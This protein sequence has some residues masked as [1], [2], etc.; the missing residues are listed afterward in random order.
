[1]PAAEDDWYSAVSGT[2][3]HQGD[4]VPEFKVPVVSSVQTEPDGALTAESGVD[5]CD[6]I[7]LTQT[8]DLFQRRGQDVLL[9][10]VVSWASVA[11]SE[12][13]AGNTLVAS[14]AFRGKLIEGSVP[15]LS[16]LH[17]RLL[18]PT[19]PWSAANFE[20]VHSAPGLPRRLPRRPGRRSPPAIVS[21]VPGAFCP[22]V[23]ALLHACWPPPRCHRFRRRGAEIVRQVRERV[24]ND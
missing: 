1:M 3:V 18:P 13:R 19:M 24:E 4:I 6:V 17:K 15:H 22:S 23:R 7:V 21:A 12:F 16:L 14:K 5:I 11:E 2:E 9:C 8:C 20:T 10:Q